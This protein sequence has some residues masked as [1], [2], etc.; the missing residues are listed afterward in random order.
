[1]GLIEP[2]GTLKHGRSK[3][4]VIELRCGL[5]QTLLLIFTPML[6]SEQRFQHSQEQ[7]PP[8]SRRHGHC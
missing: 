2:A 6:A 3:L 1:M 8:K 5:S 7:K 4:K